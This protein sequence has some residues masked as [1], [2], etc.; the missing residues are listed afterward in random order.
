MVLRAQ[1][2]SDFDKEKTLNGW[3]TKNVTLDNTH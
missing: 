1:T 3:S 2:S